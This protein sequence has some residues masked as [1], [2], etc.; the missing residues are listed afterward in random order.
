[1][2]IIRCKDQ[3]GT[4]E[5]FF[6]GKE[7]GGVEV[8]GQVMLGLISRLRALPSATEVYGLTSLHRLCFLAEDTWKSPWY[9]IVAA[10][11]PRN[12]FIEYLVPE[13]S[14][15]WPEAYMKGVAHSED[16]AVEMI[17]TAMEKSEAWKRSNQDAR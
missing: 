5:D 12:Y 10:F 1:M 8:G 2:H 4:L 11:D 14:A 15:P 9:V 7:V 17:V 13:H 3:T 6:T 16:E